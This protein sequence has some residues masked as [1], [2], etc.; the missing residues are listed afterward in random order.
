MRI[1]K[2]PKLLRRVWHDQR[3]ARHQHE[4]RVLAAERKTW[5][6]RQDAVLRDLQSARLDRFFADVDRPPI[7]Y[8]PGKQ[9]DMSTGAV[10]PTT[11]MSDLLAKRERAAVTSIGPPT[12]QRPKEAP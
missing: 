10:R 2:L 3:I 8:A 11:P 5:Q 4:L 1:P 6:R 9:R 7:S 12:F